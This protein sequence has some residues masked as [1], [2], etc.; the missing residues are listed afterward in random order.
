M[1]L[2]GAFG[3]R[4][5]SKRG[6]L[7]ALGSCRIDGEGFIKRCPSIGFLAMANYK[8]ASDDWA[9]LRIAFRRWS[10]LGVK[11]HLGPLRLILGLFVLSALATAAQT[12]LANAHAHN[13]YLHKRPLLDALEH[14]FC[15]VEAD[16]HLVDGKLL[17]AHDPEQVQTGRTL[18]TL[19]LEPLQARVKMNKGKVHAGGEDFYLLID[20]KTAAEPTY[21]ALRETLRRFEG[22]VSEFRDDKVERRAVT[23]IISGNRPIE[24][25]SNEVSRL[26]A[27]DGRLTDLQANP[28]PRLIPWISDNWTKHFQWRGDGTVSEDDKAKLQKIVSQ[29]RAQGR[30]LRFWATPDTVAGWRELRSAGVDLMNTDN[31]EGLQKFLSVPAQQ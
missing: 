26:A 30:K 27:I 8:A 6:E 12:P 20:L 24:L 13:D 3:W 9:A 15:S 7:F 22:I 31:L 1:V 17:V 5:D 19:Y 21:T 14:G 28:S 25:M 11:C 2:A 18:E 4:A 23:V 16:I 10:G 29:C